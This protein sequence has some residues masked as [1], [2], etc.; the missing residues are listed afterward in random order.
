MKRHSMDV[1]SLV[2]GL[3]F[4]ASAALFASDALDLTFF[5]IEWVIAGLLLAFGAALLLSTAR[6]KDAEE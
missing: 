2:F 5:N 6:R 4:L 1:L 3:F